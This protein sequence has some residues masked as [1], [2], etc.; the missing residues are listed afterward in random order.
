MTLE[1][2]EEAYK[3]LGVNKGDGVNH[4][5]MKEKVRKEYYRRIRLV[6]KTE[7]NAKN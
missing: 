2:T 5:F 6:M 7:L 1:W 4:S 3:Y